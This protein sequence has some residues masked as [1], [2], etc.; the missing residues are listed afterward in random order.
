MRRNNERKK[1]KLAFTL[2]MVMLILFIAMGMI[3]ALMVIYENYRG[4]STSTLWRQQEYNILQDAVE[5]GRSLIRSDD[6]PEA[7][8][9]SADITSAVSL[10]IRNFDYPVTIANETAHVYVEVYDSKMEGN[11]VRLKNIKNNA[12]ERVKMPTLMLP[13]MSDMKGTETTGGD[14]ASDATVSPETEAS[15]VGVYT[16]RARIEPSLSNRSLELLTTMEKSIP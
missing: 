6:Y 9:S 16:I 8:A 5:R 14:F 12:T 3:S 2:P 4:R 7:P 11:S 1:A 10:R 13:Q 15:G